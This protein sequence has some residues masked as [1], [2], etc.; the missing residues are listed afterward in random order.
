[1]LGLCPWPFPAHQH[2]GLAGDG[3]GVAHQ[4]QEMGDEQ[5]PGSRGDGGRR[6]VG[7]LHPGRCVA[8]RVNRDD[9]CV[10]VAGRCGGP[11]D[12]VVEAGDKVFQ[13]YIFVWR[14]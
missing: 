10:G 2:G 5:P 3:R 9:T 1:M 14:C 8:G 12:K 11:G 13:R 6:Q 7:L 4:I